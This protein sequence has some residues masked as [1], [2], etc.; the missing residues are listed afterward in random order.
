LTVLFM[1]ISNHRNGYI[2]LWQWAL[3]ML[4]DSLEV[5]PKFIFAF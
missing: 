3:G 4:R 2:H 1:A 5:A